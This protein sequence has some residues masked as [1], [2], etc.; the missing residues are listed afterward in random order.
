M[1]YK[2]SLKFSK[3]YLPRIYKKFDRKFQIYN[4]I[5]YQIFRV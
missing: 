2:N 3:N 5:F 4:K 1:F